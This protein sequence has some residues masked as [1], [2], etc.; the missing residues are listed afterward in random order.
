M[1]LS[2]INS[3]MVGAG[4]VSNTEHAYLNSVTSNVQT[5]IDE[6]GLTGVDD[7]SS[8]NDDQITIKDA[9]VVIN[10]D[11]DDV[12][13]R[14]ESDTKTQALLVDGGTGRVSTNGV[15][16]SNYQFTST[17]ESSSP[18]SAYFKGNDGS[19]SKPAN[20]IEIGGS[21]TAT[22]TNGTSISFAIPGTGALIGI[23]QAAG[24]T[25]YSGALFHSNYRV[26][27]ST[28]KLADPANYFANSDTGG[29]VCVYMSGYNHNIIIKNNSGFS[30]YFAIN[31]IAFS[32]I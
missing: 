30:K 4:D 25:G 6:V 8:S 32:G 20:I 12:D 31:I 5:Q 27:A 16:Y 7:Q 11:H 19:G 10:E 17:A 21:T 18:Y 28:T 9:E 15:A 29:K 2:R 23:L 1:A 24:G 22:M 13:F 14:V 26:T 3:S